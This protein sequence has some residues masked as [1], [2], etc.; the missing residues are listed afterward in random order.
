[1]SHTPGLWKI[2][3]RVGDSRYIL[4]SEVNGPFGH[5]EGWSEDGVTTTDEDAANA[6]RVVACVN[7]C[8]GI[9]DR[10]LELGLTMINLVDTC[11]YAEDVL[12]I[13][14]DY[15]VNLYEKE[16]NAWLACKRALT[17]FELANVGKEE[18][19]DADRTHS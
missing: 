4:E 6:R 9:S 10:A 17:A 12:Y 19:D 5:F 1:M 3:R 8:K 11:Q 15:R 7:A 13:G 16:H 14:Y 2:I 18:N